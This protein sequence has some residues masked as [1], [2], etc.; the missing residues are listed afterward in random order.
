MFDRIPPPHTHT[1]AA[2]RSR[3]FIKLIRSDASVQSESPR[4]NQEM[5]AEILLWLIFLCRAVVSV[6]IVDV[7]LSTEQSMTNALSPEFTTDSNKTV[8]EEDDKNL[9][10]TNNETEK[11]L[12]KSFKSEGDLEPKNGEKKLSEENFYDANLMENFREASADF[13]ITKLSG[14]DKLNK[15]SLNV[16]ETN[17][18]A[19][20][21]GRSGTPSLIIISDD[22]LSDTDLKQIIDFKNSVVR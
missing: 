6:P 3:T 8:I 21:K 16:S 17:D 19:Q 4:D 14:L 2:P 13:S 15:T 9:A 22:N 18:E 10:L 5:S 1:L 7:E 11:S 20:S 12:Q